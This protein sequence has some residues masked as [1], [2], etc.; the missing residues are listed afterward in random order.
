MLDIKKT[1]W[2]D[3][4]VEQLNARQQDKRF[5]PYTCP[6]DLPDCN[7][8]RTLIATPDGWVCACGEYKQ[9]WTR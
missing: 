9:D 2:N 1:P 8:H 6:G 7:K 3:A 4:L 5:H